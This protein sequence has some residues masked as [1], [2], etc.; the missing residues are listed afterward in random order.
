M[1]RTTA[2]RNDPEINVPDEVTGQNKAYLV[3]SN[4]E[5]AQ[6][7]V[8][9]VREVYT[10]LKCGVDIRMSR[11]IA[12]TYARDPKFYGA[13]WCVKCRTHLPVGEFVWQGS[14]EKLGS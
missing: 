2:D 10:H 6:G 14:N 5:R 12:E 3:L 13:T 1:G 4:E 8:R 11:D 9:P 7:F